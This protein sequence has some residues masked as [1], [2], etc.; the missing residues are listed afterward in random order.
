MSDDLKEI[1][2]AALICFTALILWVTVIV[3]AV[4]AF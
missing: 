4:E 2:T 3:F 1:L